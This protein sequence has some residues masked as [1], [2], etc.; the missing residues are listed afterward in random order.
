MTQVTCPRCG[1]D[2]CLISDLFCT[3]CGSGLLHLPVGTLLCG[4][5]WKPP[6]SPNDRF[7]HRCGYD[8]SKAMIRISE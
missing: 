3:Q 6:R 4:E 1:A 5:C 8:Y 2:D 7:C